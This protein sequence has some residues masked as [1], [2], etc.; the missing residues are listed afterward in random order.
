VN[1]AGWVVGYS[2]LNDTDFF[3]THAVLW[4]LTP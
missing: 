1:S 3:T 2:F 4:S